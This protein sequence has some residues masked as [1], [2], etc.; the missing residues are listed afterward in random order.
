MTIDTATPVASLRP[1]TPTRGKP[2]AQSLFDFSEETTQW[3]VENRDKPKDDPSDDETSLRH[4]RNRH[5]SK[6]DLEKLRKSRAMERYRSRKESSAEREIPTAEKNTKNET[7]PLIRRSSRTVSRLDR[8]PIR[9]P[10]RSKEIPINSNKAATFSASPLQRKKSVHSPIIKRR[11]SMARQSIRRKK[12]MESF[13]SKSGEAYVNAKGKMA[14]RGSRTS[15]YS[16]A[17][18][19]AGELIGKREQSPLIRSTWDDEETSDQDSGWDILIVDAIFRKY[20]IS[21]KSEGEETVRT[22]ELWKEEASFLEEIKEIRDTGKKISQEEQKEGGKEDEAQPEKDT[23]KETVVNQEEVREEDEKVS[24]KD[25]EKETVVDEALLE[26]VDQNDEE[27]GGENGEAPLEK[28]EEK[29]T[30]FYQKEVVENEEALLSVPANENE[31][32]ET[33]SNRSAEWEEENDDVE[34]VVAEKHEEDRIVSMWLDNFDYR[35]QRITPERS[36]E[37]TPPIA[38]EKEEND[39]EKEE[40]EESIPVR[41]ATEDPLE[42][43][44]KIADDEEMSM[45]CPEEKES[46]P[47]TPQLEQQEPDNRD[48]SPS[49]S[50]P[51]QTSAACDV[52]QLLASFDLPELEEQRADVSATPQSD[53]GAMRERTLSLD[54]ALRLEKD[55]SKKESNLRETSEVKS[56]PPPPSAATTTTPSGRGIVKLMARSYSKMVNKLR[57]SKETPAEQKEISSREL[58]PLKEETQAASGVVTPLMPGAPGSGRLRRRIKSEA[59]LEFEGEF[60]QLSAERRQSDYALG[61]VDWESDTES[62]SS[63]ASSQASCHLHEGEESGD[64]KKKKKKRR[65]TISRPA[66]GWVK[67]IAAKFGSGSQ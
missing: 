42:T 59:S 1:P 24:Q 27:K 64:S 43:E 11:N 15:V 47:T 5:V 2:R 26:K 21:V 9:R 7:P 63:E 4:R 53:S 37:K 16:L 60:S 54:Q 36:P 12:T 65:G 8:R 10:S 25:T 29:E 39:D 49:P 6:E 17:G 14:A 52:G 55:E 19:L 30:V 58:S 62:V 67:R 44:T 35:S 45:T 34:T 51:P 41:E 50:P 3:V 61:S 28:D 32:E 33:K 56:P 20:S 40:K 48:P 23:E 31:E 57:S 13:S 22:E 38:E 66:K 46:L 18:D